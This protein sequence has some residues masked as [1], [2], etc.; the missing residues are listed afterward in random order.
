[1]S[2]PGG[3]TPSESSLHRLI[4]V[5]W[6]EIRGIVLKAVWDGRN[7]IFHQE[8][9]TVPQA[10]AHA[11]AQIQTQLRALVYLYTPSPLIRSPL[12]LS[13]VR[14]FFCRKSWGQLRAQFMPAHH[15]MQPA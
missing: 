3:T 1:M 9:E 2:W 6:T 14:S 10:A 8:D 5:Q 13:D 15:M 12:L 4:R 7:T 11:A